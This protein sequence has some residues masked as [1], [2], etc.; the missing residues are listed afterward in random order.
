MH[1]GPLPPLFCILLFLDGPWFSS[2]RSLETNQPISLFRV[3]RIP[4]LSLSK[5]EQ[6]FSTQFKELSGKADTVGRVREIVVEKDWQYKHMILIMD[7]TD[8]TCSIYSLAP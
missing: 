6:L 5:C 7:S 2:E 3:K 4:N 1:A 8:R